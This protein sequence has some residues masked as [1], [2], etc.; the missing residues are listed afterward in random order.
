P[1]RERRR[2]RAAA[3]RARLHR[4]RRDHRQRR[5]ASHRNP[6]ALRVQPHRRR[7]QSGDRRRMMVLEI[8]GVS[9]SYGALR[10]LRLQ[11]LA[12]ASGESWAIVGLDQAAAELFVNLITGAT[13]PDAGE[14]RIFGRPTAAIADS[15]DWLATVD[16]FGIVSD[17][18]VLLD[19]LS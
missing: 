18:A 11:Q 1:R 7:S 14:V 5:G 9:K 17:R 16:R 19:R 12:V 10:P 15:T 6:G 2:E 13:L 3:D 4:V 8:A